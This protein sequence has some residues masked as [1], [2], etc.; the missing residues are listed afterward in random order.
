MKGG[1]VPRA[2]EG[3]EWAVGLTTVSTAS[4]VAYCKVGESPGIHRSKA[5]QLTHQTLR[6]K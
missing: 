5:V 3:K 2:G 4:S 1:A 6:Q